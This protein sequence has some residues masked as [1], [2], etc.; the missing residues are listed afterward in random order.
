MREWLRPDDRKD[1]VRHICLDI[2]LI[3]YL[4]D[5]SIRISCAALNTSFKICSVSKASC[6][7]QSSA[8]VHC[9]TI[10]NIIANASC[11]LATGKRSIR[12]VLCYEDIASTCTLKGI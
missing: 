12:I 6:N 11:S 3:K 7:E 9:D 1:R 10:P 2:L 8:T 5:K 4:P